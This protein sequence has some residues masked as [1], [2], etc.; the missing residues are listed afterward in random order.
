MARQATTP[1]SH[2]RSVRT[3]KRVLMTSGRAAKVVPT[4]YVPLLPGDSASGKVAFDVVLKEMPRPLLNGVSANFQAWVV[5]KTAFPQFGGAD[6]IMHAMTGDP[7]KTLGAADRT[8]PPFFTV[9]SGATVT[10]AAASEFFKTLGIHI[11]TGK[12][13]NSDL[14]DAFSLVY[15]F[16]LAAHSNK[17]TRRKYASEDIAEA[18]ALPR[19]FWPSWRFSRAVPDYER[20]LIVGSLDLDV[21]AGQIPVSGFFGT[22]S[23]ALSA[24]GTVGRGTTV[25]LNETS[26]AL[27]GASQQ[28]PLAAGTGGNGVNIKMVGASLAVLRPAVFAEMTGIQIPTTL[29]DIDKA[30]T[31]QAFAKLRTAYAGNDATGFDNDDTLIALLMAGLE[32]P[33]AQFKRP[34]LLDSQRVPV[35]FAE[36]H[37]TDAANLDD[38]VTTGRASVVLSLNVPALPHGGMIIF[39]CEVM[40]ERLDERMSDEHMLATAYT[41]LPNAMRDVQRTEPVDMILNRRLDAK[42]STPD[43]LYGYEPMNDKWNV[44]QTGLGGDFYQATPGTQF[45]QQRAAIW[46]TDIVNPVFSTSHY[47]APAAFPHAVFADTLGSAFEVVCRHQVSISGLTQIGDIL[48]EA[49]NDYVEVATQT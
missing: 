31:T 18:C 28:H 5:P 22:G 16:R 32:V 8:P 26:T 39:T 3:H 12:S 45:S 41:D 19:A 21:L 6:E 42:H 7:I 38:S 1:V 43:G 48:M 24:A 46:M 47:L 17:L 36:R 33:E 30:R 10:T 35:G 25:A 29:A 20:A 4:G 15:N 44:D 37:A 23:P 9:L 11:P 13:I 34:W 2:E 27:G 14:I 40:P 49:N